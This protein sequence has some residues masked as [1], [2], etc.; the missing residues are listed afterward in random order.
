M[1]VVADLERRVEY[2]VDDEGALLAAILGDGEGR[3]AQRLAHDVDADALVLVAHRERV[4]RLQAPEQRHAATGHDALLD[5]GASRAQRIGDAVLLLVDLDLA[6][7]ADLDDGDALAQLGQTLLQLLL[8]VLGRRLGYLVLD[9]LHA[10]LDLLGL[11]L[12]AHH[13]R[14]VLGHLDLADLAEVAELDLLELGEIGLVAEHR[15]AGRDGNVAQYV[16][17]VV[18]EAGR[19]DGAHLQVD[20]ET[21]D[22]ER[23]ERL[24]LDLL[25]DDE[26]LLALRVR[27][28]ERRYELLHRAD[29]LLAD[30]HERV[31]EVAAGALVRV[32][33]VGRDVAAVE[34][35]TLDHLELVK[36]RLAVLHC[37]HAILANL[38]STAY[39]KKLLLLL[40]LLT[41]AR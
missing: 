18:A 13:E 33:E 31:L 24:A 38:L 3:H 32:D 28:L 11:A 37:D 2:L 10:H 17:A 15:A 16:L 35:E 26:Q 1:C 14:V 25:G 9:L 40:L 22:D 20:L 27:Q 41:N 12:A 21:V 19:L 5:G 36:Q 8:L 34:L 30:E 6:A 23:G 29:L 7:A 39:K 4:E